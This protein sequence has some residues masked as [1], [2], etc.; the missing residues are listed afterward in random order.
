MVLQIELESVQSKLKAR[1]ETLGATN[2]S[3]ETTR[4]QVAQLQDTRFCR[5][6]GHKVLQASVADVEQQVTIAQSD[7]TAKGAELEALQKR[8]QKSQREA[9]EAR[10]A[11][12]AK[13]REL[14]D[15]KGHLEATRL[16]GE[17]AAAE[18]AKDAAAAAER[19]SNLSAKVSGMRCRTIS[20]G[21]FHLTLRKT[22]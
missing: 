19:K 1:E 17:S 3:L 2:T 12:A 9:V 6:Q 20:T 16:E 5:T 11:V 13:E 18:A 15:L 21:L 14:A 4:A 8:L 7:S 10:D 22:P